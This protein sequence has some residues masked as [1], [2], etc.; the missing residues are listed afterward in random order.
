MMVSTTLTFVR[1]PAKT[2]NFELRPHAFN[3]LITAS[4]FDELKNQK[5]PVS[6]VR[7]TAVPLPLPLDVRQVAET[8]KRLL[9]RHIVVELGVHT[10]GCAG[11]P[12]SM[13]DLS[14]G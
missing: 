5:Y 13:N 6:S 14:S 1:P 2:Q 8:A 7:R 9:L 3:T 12:E 11:F 10:D 4:T